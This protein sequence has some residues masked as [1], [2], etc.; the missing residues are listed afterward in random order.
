MVKK[1]SRILLEDFQNIDEFAEAVVNNVD[2]NVLVILLEKPLYRGVTGIDKPYG[3]KAI[4][5]DRRPYTN[6]PAFQIMLDREFEKR[7]FCAKRSNSIFATSKLSF[8]EKFGNKVV[9]VFPP[10]GFCFVWN[11][12]ISDIT[13]E[14]IIKKG[15]SDEIELDVEKALKLIG[16]E[17]VELAIKNIKFRYI[18]YAPE[19]II[20]KI[21]N[22]SVAVII[23]KKFTDEIAREFIEVWNYIT[24]NAPSIA[25]MVKVT[26]FV[27]LNMIS[28]VRKSPALSP[29]KIASVYRFSENS[30]IINA[31]S[32]KDFEAAVHSGREVMIHAPYYFYVE[33]ELYATRVRDA[34]VKKLNASHE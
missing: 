23:D 9:T 34:I 14:N 18:Q 1:I 8:A 20:K 30:K 10:K 16:L 22:I 13:Y 19:D 29:E 27:D 24:K 32:D 6:Y 33:R 7:G 5:T 26:L 15:G 4:R 3:K 2:H 21:N 25:N 31:F 12:L 17:F 11:K 28:N